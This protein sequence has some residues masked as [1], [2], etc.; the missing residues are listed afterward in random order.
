MN[1][2]SGLLHVVAALGATLVLGGCNKPP[3][4][5]AVLPAD[6]SAMA[7]VTDIA[8]TEQVKTALQLNDALKG[9]DITVTTTKGDVRLSGMVDTQA[10]AD[11]AIQI[12]R[13][14]QGAHAIHDELT[15]KK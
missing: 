4:A 7:N 10:Q 8:V 6:A 2:C 1:K 5:V 11:A 12:A 13:A 3:E 14:T 9:F 15:I